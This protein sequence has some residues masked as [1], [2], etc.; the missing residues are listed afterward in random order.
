M[1]DSTYKQDSESFH[2]VPW[3]KAIQYLYITIIAGGTS[4]M[5]YPQRFFKTITTYTQLLSF[6]RLITDNPIAT[7]A[8]RLIQMKKNLIA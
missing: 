2:I 1:P 3:R 8:K 7:R 5:E 6:Y 4:K